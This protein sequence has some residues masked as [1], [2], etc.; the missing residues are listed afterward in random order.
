MKP[1]VLLAM[2]TVGE[3]HRTAAEALAAWWESRYPGAFR[4]EVLDFTAAVGDVRLDARHKRTWRW[5]LRW[6]RSAYYGQRLLDGAVPVGLSRGLQGALLRGHA[7]RAAEFLH[8]RRD[9]LVVA[10]HFFTL[11]ALALAKQRHGVRAPL[12]GLNP[13]PLDAHALWAERGADEMIVFSEAAERDLVR[14]GVPP[15][16]VTRFPYLMRPEFTGPCGREEAR[17]ELELEPDAFVVLH[18]AGGEGIAGPVEATVRAALADDAPLTY[19]VLCGRNE[20]LRHRL[21]ALG[22]G[23]TG[24]TRL[25]PLGFRRD[26]RRW[27]CAADV[28]VG[29]AGPASTFEALISGRPVAH[30]G[31]AAANERAVLEWARASGAGRYLPRPREL[32][33]RLAA[34]S[35]FDREYASMRRAARELGLRNGGGRL[36][37]HLAARYLAGQRP[38]GSA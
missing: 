25:L 10:T 11:Q 28:F 5:M 13:D 8:D 3:G 21:A 22:A 32:A 33:G 30:T 4:V 7:R 27:L 23:H 34:W 6:P 17:A 31:Y 16:R 29:K 2:I 14:R 37:D 24:P 20:A 15:A 35:R 26:V 9:D 1:R 19:V 18:G 12:V 38:P 36:A